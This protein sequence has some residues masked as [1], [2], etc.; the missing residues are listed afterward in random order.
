MHG[1]PADLPVQALVGC[2]L[3]HIGLAMHQIQLH[4][5]GGAHISIESGWHLKDG[6][7]NLIDQAIDPP[8]ARKSYQIHRLLQQAVTAASIDPP[9]SFTV[10]FENGDALTILD[11]LP[12]YESFSL[13]VGGRE[14]YI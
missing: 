1:V 9:R 3:D 12:R 8:A 10:T 5:H 6:R 13:R 7:G 2:E 14:F 11:D 4:F